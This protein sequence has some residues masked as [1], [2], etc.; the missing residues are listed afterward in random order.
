MSKASDIFD[1]VVFPEF[2]D[3]LRTNHS[4][5]NY[6]RL[7]DDIEDTLKKPF[8]LLTREDGEAYAEI[9]KTKLA[10]TTVATRLGWIRSIAGFAEDNADRLMV[11]TAFYN[12]SSPF[13][14]IRQCVSVSDMIDNEKLPVPEQ[15]NYFLENTSDEIR[16]I[17]QLILK[18]GIKSEQ[19]RN[20]NIKHIVTDG[21]YR[22]LSVTDKGFERYI[23]IPEDLEAAID[24]YLETH[25]LVDGYFLIN[26]KGK[27]LS[28]RVLEKRYKK[29]ADRLG[30]SFTMVD[31]RNAAASYMLAGGAS[32]E[33]VSGVLGITTN[34]ISRF[35]YCVDNI[36]TYSA[37]N[38]SRLSIK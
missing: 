19:I 14:Y 16:F 12:Y 23:L 1:N 32:R 5:V 31:L 27:P 28:Q 3:T 26:S 30:F 33:D 35:N 9:L 8:L 20:L 38:Y 18:L 34:W 21:K 22:Y 29:E 37:N 4:K 10:P 2:L 11:G 17:T 6:Q 7:K 24:E 36:T 13:K 25:K 15:I